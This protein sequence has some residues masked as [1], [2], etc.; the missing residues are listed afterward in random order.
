MSPHERHVAEQIVASAVA[1]GRERNATQ[2]ALISMRCAW[3]VAALVGGAEYRRSQFNRTTNAVRSPSSAFKPFVY[4]AAILSGLRPDSRL[5]DAP[6]PNGW[7][8]NFDGRYHGWVSV[9]QAIEESLNAAAV[10]SQFGSASPK[11]L[12]W[13]VNL[14]LPR[15]CR[16]IPASSSD[17]AAPP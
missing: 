7:P 4:F 6:Q 5:L 10:T 11:S 9:A 3:T 2:G 8:R 16:T 14:A 12:T 15:R 1:D 17:P 13:L